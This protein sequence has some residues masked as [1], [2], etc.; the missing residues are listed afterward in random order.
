MVAL[1]VTYHRTWIYHNEEG[2]KR[3]EDLRQKLIAE[4]L[5]FE[6]FKGENVTYFKWTESNLIK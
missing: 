4:D 5:K 6:E 1:E 2:Y 3:I